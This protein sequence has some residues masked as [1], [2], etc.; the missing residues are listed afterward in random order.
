[1]AHIGFISVPKMLIDAFW[2]LTDWDYK[3]NNFWQNSWERDYGLDVRN[4]KYLVGGIKW[5]T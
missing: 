3:F 5:H 2:V 4:E 1:M